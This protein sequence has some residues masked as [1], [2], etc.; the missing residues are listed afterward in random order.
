MPVKHI[1]LMKFKKDTPVD[2]LAQA[3]DNLVALK[4]K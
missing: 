1:V 2:A 3:G 4:G